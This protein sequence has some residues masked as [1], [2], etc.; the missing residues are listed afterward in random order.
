MYKMVSFSVAGSDYESIGVDL[1]FLPTDE[2]NIRLCINIPI[3]DDT[4]FEVDEEFSV[5]LINVRP[6]GEIIDNTT[7]IK[8]IDDDS[9]WHVEHY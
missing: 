1:I 6:E 4:I 7:C 5:N 2:G 3:F 8:I 9:K